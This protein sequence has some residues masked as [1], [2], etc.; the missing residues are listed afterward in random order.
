MASVLKVSTYN[1]QLTTSWFPMSV[2]MVVQPQG[3]ESVN[4]SAV[5]MGC[6]SPLVNSSGVIVCTSQ[7]YLVD[8]CSPAID[9]STSDWAS[10]LVTL[11]KTQTDEI[12]FNHTVLTFGFDTAVTLTGIEMDLFLCP[13]WGI[14]APFISVYAN[15]ESNL[16]IIFTTLT[17]QNYIPSQSSCDVNALSTISIPLGDS[18][19]DRSFLTW[20]ILVSSFNS[21]IDWVHVGEVRFLGTDLQRTGTHYNGQFSGVSGVL[22]VFHDQHAGSCSINI[23]HASTPS[24][25]TT[26]EEQPTI[27]SSQSSSVSTSVLESS[28]C[29][30]YNNH[31]GDVFLMTVP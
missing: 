16:A 4:G 31:E 28:R 14:S 30:K 27:I 6:T 1:L 12:T 17:F 23:N 7:N 29:S 18:F 10:Q 11:R 25:P 15:E 20:H 26:T 13:E 19:R 24:F 5:N 8:G 2:L 22:I 21:S 9:T 3:I